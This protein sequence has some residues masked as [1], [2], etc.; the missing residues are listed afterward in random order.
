MKVK[1]IKKM[2]W[3]VAGAIGRFLV[4][5]FAMNGYGLQALCALDGNSL[6]CSEKH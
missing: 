5:L 4:N 2:A 3:L 6:S 1:D